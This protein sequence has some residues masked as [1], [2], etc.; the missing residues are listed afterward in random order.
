MAN[1]D[2]FINEVSEEVRRDRLFALLRR[3]GWAAALAVLVLVGGAAWN[4]YRR[5]QANTQAQAFGDALL[6]AL[7]NNDADA[8]M[9]ALAAVPA[10]TPEAE[11]ILALLQA[12]E[13]AEGGAAAARLRALAG[14]PDLPRRY[15]DLALLKA[16]MLAPA[17]PGEAMATMDRLAQPGA[18]YRAL[19]MEQQ[20]YIRLGEGDFEAGLQILRQLQSEP[21]T[22]PGL[23]QRTMQLIVALEARATLTDAAEAPAAT[24]EDSVTEGAD[25]APEDTPATEERTDPPEEQTDAD[26]TAG[27]PASE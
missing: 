11:I 9:A 8:R 17:E 7:D 2:S 16:Q 15:S 5:A 18:P 21:Q 12:G 14:N 22:T 23:Q 25:A 19:A 10:E 1:S 3:W 20:A 27:I 4:E 24:A 13:E 6:Q 26:G